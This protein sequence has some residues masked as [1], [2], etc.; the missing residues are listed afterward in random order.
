MTD[1]QLPNGWE[2]FIT[3]KGKKY[4]FNTVTET[5]Q[6]KIPTEAAGSPKVLPPG[7]NKKIDLNSGY[8]YY[9]NKTLKKS[10][11]YFPSGE[12]SGPICSNIRGLKWYGNSC[13]LDSTLIALFAVPSAFSEDLLTM[14]LANRNL[15][16]LLC[17]NNP[18]DDLKNRQIVQ[19]QLRIVVNSIRGIGPMV[20]TCFDLRKTLQ[21]CPNPEN[22]YN[23]E[24]KDA[25]EFL[26]YLLSL[27]PVQNAIKQSSTYATNSKQRNVDLNDLVKT[28]Q[29]ID[30]KAS[31]IVSV[32][33]LFLL[34]QKSNAVPIATYLYQRQDNY[35]NFF[36]SDNIF[37]PEGS[38]T[39]YI[40]RITDDRVLDAPYII[41]SLTRV[42]AFEDFIEA[43]VIPDQKIQLENGKRFA[44]SAIVLFEGAHYTCL[45]RCDDNWYYYND[46]GV[47]KSYTIK[48]VG[49]Y[50][51]IFGVEPSPT[52][53][54]TQYFYTPL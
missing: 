34:R 45:F 53:N 26:Y 18:V 17:G 47:G 11:W 7:W 29:N 30:T 23:T 2:V 43:P 8:I 32:S 25:G 19:N 42:S 4:Y 35:P 5:T 40:R 48:K 41:F 52:T 21:R 27:F 15:G 44:L 37:Y 24:I 13:Y 14:N 49:K 16:K 46:L 39:G 10:S 9:Y 54:G 6:W 12:S 50:A 20:N 33:D 1:I 28:S 3:E 38:T 51:N 36:D 22:F 31:V